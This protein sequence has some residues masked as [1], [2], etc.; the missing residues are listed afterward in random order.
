M[1]CGY[2]GFLLPLKSCCPRQSLP[3]TEIIF[4][5]ATPKAAKFV[6]VL[7]PAPPDMRSS[8]TDRGKWGIS[9]DNSLNA[10]SAYQ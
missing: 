7:A 10:M 6:A 8:T 1:L 3:I 9:R 5:D 2:A 4:T